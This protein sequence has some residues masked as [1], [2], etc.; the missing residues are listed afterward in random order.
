[1][2]DQSND[3]STLAR[4][5][6]ST[7]ARPCDLVVSSGDSNSSMLNSS[8]Q[9]PTVL[10]S[11]DSGAVDL[12]GGSVQ[13][14]TAK[15]GQALSDLTIN[16][17]IYSQNWQPKTC[18]FYINGVTGYA[19]FNNNVF[20][21][22]GL[23]A[24]TGDIGGF[25]I[26]SS[27]IKD[28]SDTMGLSSDVTTG[29]DIRFWAGASY[30]NRANAAF[31]VTK[32]GVVAASKITITGGSVATSTFSGIINQSNLNIANQGWTI[33]T[34]FSATS[35]TV[36]SWT[37][38]VL[39]DS[40][41]TAYN[42]SAGNTGTMAG[43]YYIYFDLGVSSTAYQVTATAA[44]AVGSGKIL[45]AM[46]QN[47]AGEAI[48]QVFGGSGGMNVD[49]SDIVA[50]SV[51]TNEIAA[52]TITASNI[53]ANTITA[54]LM[55]VGQ[56]SAI[57]ADMGAITAGTITLASTGYVRSGQTDFN[58]GVGFFLGRSGGASKFSIGDPA[59]SNITWDGSTLDVVGVQKMSM[60]LTAGEAISYGNACAAGL[61]QSDGG[62]HKDMYANGTYTDTGSGYT[63][64]N[65]FTIA[66]QANRVLVIVLTG[67]FNN[68]N[69]RLT[70]S[71]TATWNGVSMT[72]IGS[73]QVIYPTGAP[74]NSICGFILANPDSGTH[75]LVLGNLGG[76]GLNHRGGVWTAY[77]LYNCK[78][79]GIPL[80][81]VFNSGSSGANYPFPGTTIDVSLN[82]AV[83]GCVAL[84]YNVDQPLLNIIGS[85]GDNGVMIPKGPLTLTKAV[86]GGGSYVD[87]AASVMLEPYTVPTLGIVNA[88]SK[89]LNT[90]DYWASTLYRSNGFIG[91]AD[92]GITVGNT[93]PVA[94]QG[95]ADGVGSVGLGIHYYLND[96]LGAIGS[97][98][99]TNTRKV[100]IGVSNSQVLVTNIW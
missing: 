63:E 83:D 84:A 16:S 5:Y 40:K 69:S 90:T 36:V 8:G 10:N 26:G 86:P 93:G 41:G 18:G 100:G 43:R 27:Y 71:S 45:L 75:N 46:A 96:V 91:F 1:M 2:A 54:G 12:T 33:T 21:S 49:G 74:C 29:D 35:A 58:T 64:T 3:Y 22:G 47:N 30:A 13:D 39:T 73:S 92:S 9:N 48:F 98:P 82:S 89:A 62:I 38:G 67:P 50:G 37:S 60:I 57:S 14:T 42:I 77:S 7:M 51:T 53:A 97:S 68:G 28:S 70:G 72:N 20:I 52:N 61:Y 44:T 99:G 23:S 6:T 66:N 76:T 24:S 88:S 31:Y 55:N 19:E 11:S 56:L 34:V 79:S 78:Q 15:T 32:S 25:L 80:A 65:A 95:V 4:P 94:I 87:I 85:G 81:S 17:S 59:G